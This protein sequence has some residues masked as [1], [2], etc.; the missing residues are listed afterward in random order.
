MKQQRITEQDYI[1]AHRKA[2]RDEEIAQFGKQITHRTKVQKSKRVYDR[3]GGKAALR[4][5]PFL[6]L[7]VVYSV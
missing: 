5:L 1:K 3:K 6:Y 7:S 2:S 4:K